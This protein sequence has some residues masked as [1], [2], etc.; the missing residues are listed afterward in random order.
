[1][2]TTELSF[3]EKRY[4]KSASPHVGRGSDKESDSEHLGRLFYMV[5]DPNRFARTMAKNI[6]HAIGIRNIVEFDDLKAALHH[7]GGNPVD[8]II[9]DFDAPGMTGAEFVWRLRRSKDGRIQRTPVIMVSER[10]DET[11]IRAA[12]DFGVNEFLPKPFSQGGLYSRIHRSVISPKPFIIAP[13]YIGPDR[14]GTDNKTGSALDRRNGIDRRDPVSTPAVV[15]DFTGPAP[16]RVEIAKPGMAEPQPVPAEAEVKTL[17]K[18]SPASS[19]LSETTAD[20]GLAATLKAR[21]D[22]PRPAT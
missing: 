8:V 10:V 3:V 20:G 7:T 5:A 14:H 15:L 11:R 1:M 9:A 22:N 12:I 16:T 4:R 6:L 17:A 18:P 21:I 2:A 13:N 19:A